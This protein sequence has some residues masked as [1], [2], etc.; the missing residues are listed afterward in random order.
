[1]YSVK[2]RKIY[3]NQFCLEC[4]IGIHDFEI[5]V[6]QKVSIDVTLEV[7]PPLEHDADTLFVVDYD[8]IREGVFALVK[9]RR[10]DYQERLCE[11]IAKVCFAKEDVAAVIVRT[12]KPDVYPDCD[13]VCF[14]IH[15]T[16][17]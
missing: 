6:K 9:G 10:Y 11:D 4:E 5:G 3:L 7:S 15:A 2:T 12:G 8:Y 14:E 13:S 17:N 1:M 16:R